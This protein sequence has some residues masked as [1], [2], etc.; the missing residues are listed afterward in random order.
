MVSAGFAASHRL[1]SR[2]A[3]PASNNCDNRSICALPDPARD[4]A[5]AGLGL[6]SLLGRGSDDMTENR[7]VSF[8][9]TISRVA[10]IGLLTS[11]GLLQACSNGPGP[12]GSTQ[13]VYAAD[14]AG[15]ARSCDAPGIG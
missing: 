13:R 8:W 2:S 9:A 3:I 5:V 6:I 10:S 11:C 7:P 15:A 4:S 12:A 14:I 1:P